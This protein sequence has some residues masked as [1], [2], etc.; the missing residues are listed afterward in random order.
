VLTRMRSLFGV[1]AGW[2]LEQALHWP[3]DDKRPLHDVKLRT[4]CMKIEILDQ[5]RGTRSIQDGPWS[6]VMAPSKIAK[7]LS[8]SLETLQQAVA[9]GTVHVKELG[10]R[11]WRVHVNDLPPAGQNTGPAGPLGKVAAQQLDVAG[12]AAAVR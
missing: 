6:E 7:R 4:M 8:I 10:E 9:N 11:S 5:L 12:A 2:D 3:P 1:L